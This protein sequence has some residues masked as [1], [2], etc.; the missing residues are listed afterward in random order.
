MATD[1][2]GIEL[3]LLSPLPGEGPLPASAI[4]LV[5]DTV[6][7]KD[8]RVD[9]TRLLSGALLDISA[10]AGTTSPI[11]SVNTP[12]GRS[13][14]Q[15]V[16]YTPVAF[17]TQQGGPS[18]ALALEWSDPGDGSPYSMR[19]VQCLKFNGDYTSP[20]NVWVA[21]GSAGAAD[22]LFPADEPAFATGF[23]NLPA[24]YNPANKSPLEVLRLAGSAVYQV[25]AF[26]SFTVAGAGTRT[27][28]VGTSFA[29]GFKS[30]AW[31]TSNGT[32]VAAGSII[33]KDGA[34]VLNALDENEQPIGEANDGAASFSVPA[35]T[36]VLGESR[37]YRIEATNSKGAA[38]SREVI[39]SGAYEIFYGP[40]AGA[41]TTSEQVRALPSRLT[42]DANV[43]TLNTGN[44][45]KDFVLHLPPGKNLVSIIDLDALNKNV[46]AEY[47][48]S[49]LMVQDL[50]GADT[51]DGEGEPAAGTLYVKSQAS[52]YTT[53]HRHQVTLS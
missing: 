32:N 4:L 11:F 27:V 45:L 10:L 28:P 47:S 20:L 42:T 19:F 39:I 50:A 44:T 43:F 51:L 46:T 40:R 24:G 3:S 23:G 35:F 38:L 21:L 34:S 1:L 12:S 17:G 33:V 48:E 26:T 13:Q 25:P 2:P 29:A 8:H 36:A 52:A 37:R 18:G 41:P 30:F 53:S 14:E 31:A 15:G 6:T 5:R 22:I 49:E 16:S 9:V 7:G